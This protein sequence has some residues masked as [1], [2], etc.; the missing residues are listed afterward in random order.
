MSAI[1]NT[2]LSSKNGQ[3][4]SFLQLLLKTAEPSF[5]LPACIFCHVKIKALSFFVLIRAAGV[6]M[7]ANGM[8]DQ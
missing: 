2:L 5:M 3:G 8:Y 6:R 4:A 7:S 1:F